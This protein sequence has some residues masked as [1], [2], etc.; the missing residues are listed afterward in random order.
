M[1]AGFLGTGWRFPVM[2][3]RTAE[4]PGQLELTEGLERIDQAI[5]LILETE[6]G[7]RVMR[8]DFGCGLRRYLMKP[9][10][11]AT[12][13]LLKEDVD[14]ALTRWE[15]RIKVTQ[16]A[17]EPGDDPAVVLI[18]VSYVLTRTGQ[19]RNFVYP[20]FLQSAP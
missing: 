10:T 3:V 6:P 17:V 1:S 4:Q 20:F 18:S 5:S 13:T 7:E 11:V 14:S 19:S 2:P 8:P 16:V 12:R 9:N 15:P